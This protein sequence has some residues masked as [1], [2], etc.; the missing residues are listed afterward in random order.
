MFPASAVRVIVLFLICIAPALAQPHLLEPCLAE[1]M[2]E[3]Q[4]S[5]KIRII[6][7]WDRATAL[8]DFLPRSAGTP[9]G[10]FCSH[11]VSAT[12]TR[13]TMCVDHANPYIDSPR[14]VLWSLILTARG[15]ASLVDKSCGAATMPTHTWRVPTK[16]SQ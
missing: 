2:R 7:S 14:K 5:S 15:D 10:V 1:A 11:A 3:A 4:S 13:F 12:G 16:N 9:D 8:G 6:P